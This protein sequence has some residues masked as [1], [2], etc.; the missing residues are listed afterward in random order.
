MYQLVGWLQYTVVVPSS[1][2]DDTDDL[3]LPSDDQ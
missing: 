2:T 3:V 1:T